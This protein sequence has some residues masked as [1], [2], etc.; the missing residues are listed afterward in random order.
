MLN[1]YELSCILENEQPYQ[2]EPPVKYN[3][4]NLYDQPISNS[5]G[6][7]ADLTPITDEDLMRYT[8]PTDYDPTAGY[9]DKL[10]SMDIPN[11]QTMNNPGKV[12]N[13][14]GKKFYQSIRKQVTDEEYKKY[15]GVSW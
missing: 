12:Q 1:F 8:T 14:S 9:N 2:F 3:L 15:T 10:Y 7:N 4:A 11:V 13:I 6:G 5:E